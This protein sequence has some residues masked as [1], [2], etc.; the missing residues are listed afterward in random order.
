MT[1]V[2]LPRMIYKYKNA[3]NQSMRREMRSSQADFQEKATIE[4]VEQLWST[5]KV[6]FTP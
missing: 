2:T 4:D 6:K 1:V 5:F 3:D